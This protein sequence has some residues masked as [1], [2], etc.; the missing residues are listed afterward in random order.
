MVEGKRV[1]RSQ[2][3]AEQAQ[4]TRAAVLDAASSCFLAH[5]YARTT[6]KDIAAEAGVAVQTVFAQGGKAALLLACV[7]RATVADDEE[8]PLVERRPF[9]RLFESD[10]LSEMLEAWREL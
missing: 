3:R 8:S 10:S 9:V 7:D 5:G 1:Y 2:L 4:R 6:M